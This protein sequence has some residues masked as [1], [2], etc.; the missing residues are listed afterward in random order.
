MGAFFGALPDVVVAL[1]EFGRG[2]AGIAITVG[3]ILLTA[4]LLFGAKALRDTHG[5]L[6]SI[7]GMMGATVA[8]WWAFG[9]LP[10]AWVYFMDGQRDLLEGVVIPEALG[11]GGR[12]MS[13]NFYQVFRDVVVMAETTVAMLAFAV[14]AAA[15]Q[16][17]YPRA[18]AQDEQARPQSGGYK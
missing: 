4:A 17:R 11:I 16:K 18:L 5:W 2:W 15:V 1:W 8:A 10:S 9:I 3:S 14:M 6:A 13:A 7:L 12:V